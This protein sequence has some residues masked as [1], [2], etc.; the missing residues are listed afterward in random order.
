MGISDEELR[1]AA[2]ALAGTPGLSM[3]ADYLVEDVFLLAAAFDDQA[4]FEA[5]VAATARAIG[6]LSSRRVMASGLKYALEGW[7]SYHYQHRVSQGLRADCRIVF[8]VVDE[9]IEVKGFGHRNIPSDLYERMAE[10]R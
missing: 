2:L 3:D 6:L 4:E 5:A 9:G 1:A 8:K 10:T 7:Q